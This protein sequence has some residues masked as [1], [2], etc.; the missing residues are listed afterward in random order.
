MPSQGIVL[1]EGRAENNV[2]NKVKSVTVNFIVLF[3]QF[4]FVFYFLS[5]ITKNSFSNQK[6]RKTA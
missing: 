2:E 4:L 3:L 6:T 5:S 1:E